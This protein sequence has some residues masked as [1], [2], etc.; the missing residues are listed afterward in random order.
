MGG[1]IT[2]EELDQ[3][4]AKQIDQGKK[5]VADYGIHLMRRCLLEEP[6]HGAIENFSHMI[7][8][9]GKMAH[10]NKAFEQ[11]QLYIDDIKA[12]IAVRTAEDDLRASCF[13]YH[14]DW[15]RIY[16]LPSTGEKD[17]FDFVNKLTQHGILQD[18]QKMCLFIRTCILI[19]MDAYGKQI[20]D[21]S[22]LAQGPNHTIDALAK[23]IVVLI[24]YAQDQ[25]DEYH[26]TTKVG[27]FTNILTVI[28]LIM[29][30]D[31]AMLDQ[32]FTPK[33]YFRLYS[34]IIY[35]LHAHQAHLKPIEINLL[36]AL[37]NSLSSL[38]PDFM[39]S[40][41]FCWLGLI[42]H[43]LFLPRMMELPGRKGWDYM[44]AQFA[45]LF[46]FLG[47]ILTP[48]ISLMGWDFYQGVH[49]IVA[50]MVHDYPEFIVTYHF[51]LMAELPLVCAQV[52]NMISS[53]I[54]RQLK[55]PAPAAA[56]Y[57][58][59]VKP[60]FLLSPPMPSNFTAALEQRGLVEGVNQYLARRDYN[61]LYEL[62]SKLY[63]DDD[64]ED[65]D[66]YV[67]NCLT[68]YIAVA[69]IETNPDPSIKNRNTALDIYHQLFVGLEIEGN[70]LFRSM[71]IGRST[72][73]PQLALQPSAI[74]QPAHLLL[75]QRHFTPLQ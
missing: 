48:P 50:V 29:V 5:S 47:T 15:L 73:L 23:M 39:P 8:S 4:L 30:N 41:A 46:K 70:L 60:D 2:L 33:P 1:I 37:N 54:P 43:R 53:A 63:R 71:L 32:K 59:K 14:S 17:H 62:K 20:V 65:H 69:D 18:E 68:L 52:R 57:S 27:L 36:F 31:Q 24:R 16:Q 38:Q 12:N 25:T 56:F 19:T 45:N 26:N 21:N 64:P 49:R 74:P 67:I 55:C 51:G 22:A 66:A 11:H 28:A 35:H 42:S 40:F 9:Y 72:Y 3:Q 6:I 75:H 7:A 58:G 10:R 13:F 61:F 44:R 34:S